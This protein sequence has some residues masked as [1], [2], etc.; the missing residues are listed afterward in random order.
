VLFF[1]EEEASAE[2]EEEAAPG[3]AG[4]C[5]PEPQAAKTAARVNIAKN[6]KSRRKGFV[7][8]N[9]FIINELLS[10][11]LMNIHT[12]PWYFA[13]NNVKYVPNQDILLHFPENVYTKIYIQYTHFMSCQ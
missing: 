6:G 5:L 7:K 10:S 3:D 8:R 12:L 1:P 2:R 4:D 9:F 13:E 11:I